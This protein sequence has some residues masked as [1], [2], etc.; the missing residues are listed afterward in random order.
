MFDQRVGLHRASS[1]HDL[2]RRP[3]TKN[4]SMLSGALAGPNHRD[5]EFTQHRARHSVTG[6]A[7]RLHR[8]PAAPAFHTPSVVPRATRMR[9]L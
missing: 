9:G 5:R 6:R 2:P 7:L 8:A 3:F 1:Q 4:A